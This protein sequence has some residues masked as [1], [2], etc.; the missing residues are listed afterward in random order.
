MVSVEDFRTQLR[1]LEAARNRYRSA[2][3][4]QLA[5]KQELEVCTEG[6]PALKN[7]VTRTLKVREDMTV[8]G[9]PLLDEAVVS[10]VSE[11]TEVRLNV[12]EEKVHEGRATQG[13]QKELQDLLREERKAVN[14]PTGVIGCIVAL[15][16][17]LSLASAST[18]VASRVK[19]AMVH[20]F[21]SLYDDL[22]QSI[23]WE[24]GQWKL[25]PTA[26]L[27]V[28]DFPNIMFTQV[29]AVFLRLVGQEAV[30][31]GDEWTLRPDST[32]LLP[33]IEGLGAQKLSFK[34]AWPSLAN[35]WRFWKNNFVS[36]GDNLQA[37]KPDSQLNVVIG[38]Q[39]LTV[40]ALVQQASQQPALEEL[41]VE[42]EKVKETQVF[43]NELFAIPAN[44]SKPGEAKAAQLTMK[45]E[46]T[47]AVNAWRGRWKE[48]L[49]SLEHGPSASPAPVPATF[50]S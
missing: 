18:F 23:E 1:A 13:E 29:W 30:L 4:S 21:P 28:K 34:S 10:G 37:L 47:S 3:I 16:A 40:Q 27:H 25:K 46:F 20:A 11:S 8:D 49:R 2:L 7:F 24:S 15:T 32:F 39:I 14:C 5:I 9:V 31:H 44:F 50:F 38:N 17:V 35:L 19:P 36:V 45:A 6:S 42:V 33:A 12:L 22:A 41:K 48:V 26:T 43:A